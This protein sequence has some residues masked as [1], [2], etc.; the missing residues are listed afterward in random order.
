MDLES[1]RVD[2]A[3]LQQ[4][5]READAAADP[6]VAAG[7]LLELADLLHRVA[8]DEARVVR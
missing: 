6:D 4:G 8:L 1:R 2:P 3:V 5:L 7:Q